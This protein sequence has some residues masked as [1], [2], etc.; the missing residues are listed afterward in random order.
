MHYLFQL[1][2]INSVSQKHFKHQLEGAIALKFMKGLV[3]NS[4]PEKRQV[5]SAHHQRPQ[6]HVNALT[7][8][9]WILHAYDTADTGQ[10]AAMP[11]AQVTECKNH[12][13]VCVFIDMHR[14]FS[15]PDR[16]VLN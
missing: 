4:M 5:L 3:H 8:S 14:D 9:P 2:F 1:L 6:Y 7:L 11:R 10:R 16:C 13:Y 12:V 15:Q